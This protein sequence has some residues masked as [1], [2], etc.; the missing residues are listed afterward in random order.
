MTAFRINLIR[1]LTPTAKQ[2]ERI[3]WGMIS[4]LVLCGVAL[5]GIAY[6]ET[7]RLA[8][9]FG[10]RADIALL[11][12]QFR[13]EHPGQT[14]I[15]RYAKKMK[16]QLF[17]CADKLESVRWI[18]TTR[19]TLAPILLALAAPLPSDIDIAGL[20][21]DSEKRTLEFELIVPI[22]GMG[23]RVD[24]GRLIGI[25]NEDPALI[26]RVGKISSAKSQRQ[27]MEGKP[28]YVLRFTASLLSKEV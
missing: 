27:S 8:A 16:E 25:W 26:S 18:Q 11:D 4:Y 14:D 28:V 21:I 24:A 7:R 1:G 5:V 22:T 10:L 19:V 20:Q 9:T 23:E 13:N 6:Y 12:A 3:F 2:R 15:L 17:E